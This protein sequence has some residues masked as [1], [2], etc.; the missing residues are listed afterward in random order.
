MGFPVVRTDV[1]SV[2]VRSRDNQVDFLPMVLRWGAREIRYQ[3]HLSL[4]YL[5]F[6]SVYI[7]LACSQMFSFLACGLYFHTRA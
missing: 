3:D 5:L 7:I 6:A 4:Q 2:G 1:C